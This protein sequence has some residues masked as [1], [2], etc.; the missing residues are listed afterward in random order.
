[1]DNPA[2][3][4]FGGSLPKKES[5][6][7]RLNLCCTWALTIFYFYG[8]I[9]YFYGYI[10]MYLGKLSVSSQF[11]YFCIM[12]TQIGSNMSFLEF[13]QLAAEELLTDFTVLKP[14]TQFRNLSNWSSLNALLLISKINEKTGIFISS[15]D[16]SE[17]NTLEDIY[18]L[19]LN[20]LD[21]V[22]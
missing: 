5:K 6:T 15:A 16:L 11:I 18:T 8:R 4:L 1:M 10:I 20:K 21:G 2:L 12:L 19:I 9:L 14:E 13:T 3:G 17:L 7:N 22:K